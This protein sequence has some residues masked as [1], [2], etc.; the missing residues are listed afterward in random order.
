[1]SYH[2]QFGEDQWICEH[3]TKYMSGPG[4]FCEV[5]AF[6]GI[7]SSNTLHFEEEG[8]DGVCI[9]PLPRYARACRE[10]RKCFVF[11]YAI[12]C[13]TGMVNFFMHESDHGRSGLLSEGLRIEVHSER[14]EKLLECVNLED[15]DLLSIDTEGTELDV[16]DSIGNLRPTVVIMEFLTWGRPPRDKEIVQRMKRD[17]YEEAHRTEANLILVKR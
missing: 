1:M 11:P 4:L 15:I 14:L 17:G 2:S 3:L 12:S 7:Q 5:G 6:D 10:N 16:W 13:N 9:E 8:W